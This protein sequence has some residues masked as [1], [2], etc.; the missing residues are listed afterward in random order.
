MVSILAMSYAYRFDVDEDIVCPH[1]EE[2]V[3]MQ[4]QICPCCEASLQ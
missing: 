1:C 2:S 4:S 3:P